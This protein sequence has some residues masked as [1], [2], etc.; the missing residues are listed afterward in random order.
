MNRLAFFVRKTVEHTGDWFHF[1]LIRDS[2]HRLFLL[3]WRQ[4]T[5]SWFCHSF[6]QVP[7]EN[8]DVSDVSH[9]LVTFHH[10]VVINGSFC[11]NFGYGYFP[12]VRKLKK[13]KTLSDINRIGSYKDMNLPVVRN[14]RE[15]VWENRCSRS[16][17]TTRYHRLQRDHEGH[18]ANRTLTTQCVNARHNIRETEYAAS[19]LFDWCLGNNK[20]GGQNADSGVIFTYCKKI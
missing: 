12:F 7:D 3:F 11:P 18:G 14:T 1:F 6:G 4:K 2:R 13:K 20:G 8:K 19:L 15:L 10:S 17:R 5:L 16:C 9:G